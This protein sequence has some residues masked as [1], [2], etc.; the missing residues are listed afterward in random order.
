MAYIS[1]GVNTKLGIRSD[2]TRKART[3]KNVIVLRTREFVLGG[4]TNKSA[5]ISLGVRL[6]AGG[7]VTR[8]ISKVFGAM[9]NEIGREACRQ[10]KDLDLQRKV[11]R[12]H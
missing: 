9:I 12:G 1:L 8:R 11:R 2:V 4:K 6:V 7:D 5:Y 10:L 3:N